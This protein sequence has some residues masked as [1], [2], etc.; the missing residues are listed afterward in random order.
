MI[1]G[2]DIRIWYDD[3]IPCSIKGYVVREDVSS[4]D[5]YMNPKYSYEEQQLTLKHELEHIR[6]GD[7]EAGA[8][9][10]ALEK[11]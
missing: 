8:C 9:V 5:I 11:V 7:F 2:R 1:I 10:S 3:N 6:N 4:Y